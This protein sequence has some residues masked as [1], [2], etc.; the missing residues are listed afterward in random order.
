[1]TPQIM[2]KSDKQ[3]I[4]K[5]EFA[6]DVCELEIPANC[7]ASAIF[8][9]PGI[10]VEDL[11]ANKVI[12]TYSS[13]RLAA[14]KVNKLFKEVGQISTVYCIETAGT[15]EDQHSCKLKDCLQLKPA[16]GEYIYETEGVENGANKAY[17]IAIVIIF[18][19]KSSNRHYHPEVEEIYIATAGSGRLEIEGQE[20]QI[21]KP[22]DIAAIPI[23]KKHQIYSIGESPLEMVVTCA[24]AWT[25]TCGIYG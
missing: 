8:S 19:G 18:P 4:S 5:F 12:N 7:I 25:A 1:M 22:G 2:Y 16:D 13:V 10:P 20:D 23:G 9:S 6:G 15:L 24:D 17:S 11:L 21:M 3:I 14:G